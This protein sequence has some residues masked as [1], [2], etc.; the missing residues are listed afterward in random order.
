MSPCFNIII[1]F[2][3]PILKYNKYIQMRDIS[4]ESVGNIHWGAPSWRRPAGSL[5]GRAEEEKK[6]LIVWLYLV[7]LS[8]S[9]FSVWLLVLKQLWWARK[10]T[11]TQRF[12]GRKPASY[13][14]PSPNLGGGMLC[15]RLLVLCDRL[16]VQLCKRSCCINTSRHHP[17]L[18][19]LC[20]TTFC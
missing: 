10:H 7:M 9:L 17:Q 4:I 19:A 8:Y 6:G 1:S 2:N 15:Q 5:E 13:Q 20:S 18:L 14:F 16:H 3:K 12:L 11:N